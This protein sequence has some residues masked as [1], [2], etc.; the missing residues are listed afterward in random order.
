MLFTFHYASIN[1]KVKQ[2]QAGVD[3]FFTF[4]YVSINMKDKKEAPIQ[5]TPLH[6]TIFLL[7]F[8]LIHIDVFG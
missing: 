7:F 6:S 3:L 4:H 5:G 1:T 8:S 2:N